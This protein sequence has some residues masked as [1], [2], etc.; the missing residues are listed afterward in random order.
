VGD[1]GPADGFATLRA[2]WHTD[3]ELRRRVLREWAKIE[4]HEA[5]GF[6]AEWP[7]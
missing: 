6:I 1:A 3:P 5:R 2:L 4:P 7:E